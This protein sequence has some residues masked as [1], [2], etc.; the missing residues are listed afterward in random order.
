MRRLKQ[1]SPRLP[2]DVEIDLPGAAYLPD[3][4]VP[5]MRVKI[6]LYRRLRRAADF[7]E[8]AEFR[9]ELRDRFGPPGETA[10]RMLEL[11][12]LRLD[13]ATWQITAIHLDGDYLVFRYADRQ[14]A[15]QLVRRQSRLRLVDD[16]SLYLKIL[17]GVGNPEVLR[18]A[19]K[20]VLR[21]S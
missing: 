1:L 17:E 7:S 5:D 10:L 11:A 8:L 9:A 12:E 3:E 15:E 14:R 13:A 18:S 20:S 16:S 21:P 19:A 6:D 4:Y 2:L